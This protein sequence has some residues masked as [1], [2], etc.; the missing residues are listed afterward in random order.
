MT[1]IHLNYYLL[2]VILSSSIQKSSRIVG[3]KDAKKHEFPFVVGIDTCSE[4][5]STKS[6]CYVC[7]GSLINPGWILTAAHCFYIDQERLEKGWINLSLFQHETKQA[8][9]GGK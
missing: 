4:T 8:D 9:N 7:Q 2:S 5:K 6:T 3:G 1:K